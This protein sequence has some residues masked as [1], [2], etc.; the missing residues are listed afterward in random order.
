MGQSITGGIEKEEINLDYQTYGREG[1]VDYVVDNNGEYL[2]SDILTG[3]KD[4]THCNKGQYQP[5]DYDEMEESS[6]GNSR[7]TLEVSR[8]EHQHMHIEN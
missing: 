5:S 1:D 4:K 6:G 8:V 2:S 3:D 7:P